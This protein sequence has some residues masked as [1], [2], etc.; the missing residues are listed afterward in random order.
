MLFIFTVGLNVIISFIGIGLATGCTM[1]FFKVLFRYPAIFLLP[2]VTYF[3]M[4]SRQTGCCT[5]TPQIGL[6]KR[7]SVANLIVTVITYV[8]MIV[9]FITDIYFVELF[10]GI[11]TLVCFL[12]ILFT[13][14]FLLLDKNCCFSRSQHCL[15]ICCCGPDCY[16]FHYQYITVNNN[17]QIEVSQLHKSNDIL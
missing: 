5:T 14:L 16:K 9:L 3:V 2:A 17:G 13:T 8:I 11:F 15:C 4:G 10:F 1:D 6:S 7:L 12:S